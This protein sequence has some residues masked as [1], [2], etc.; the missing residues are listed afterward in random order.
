[1]TQDV[2]RRRYKK[3]EIRQSELLQIIVAFHF[4]VVAAAFPGDN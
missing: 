1:V 4:P 3:E 2:V